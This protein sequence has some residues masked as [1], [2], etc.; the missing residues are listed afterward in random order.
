MLEH[1]RTK[2]LE[3]SP[4]AIVAV[5]P[6]D[7][8]R[9]DQHHH[10]HHHGQHQQQHQL[11]TVTNNILQCR[12][13]TEWNGNGECNSFTD[14]AMGDWREVWYNHR[15][16][17]PY[18]CGGEDGIG[19]CSSSS[20]SSSSSRRYNC[21]PKVPRILRGD[22]GGGATAN[23]HAGGFGREYD[24]EY[25]HEPISTVM[26]IAFLVAVAA[27]VWNAYGDVIQ[28]FLLSVFQDH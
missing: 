19:R 5:H 21:R 15:H 25:F 12:V 26:V 22:D 16:N 14:R 9:I 4:V 13:S 24:D 2:S 6:D 7:L 8:E 1:I 20:S 11:N 27:H 23:N 3:R 10:N 28:S 18:A 17:D